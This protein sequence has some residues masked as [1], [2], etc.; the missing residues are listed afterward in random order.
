MLVG[1]APGFPHGIIDDISGLAVSAKK[2]DIPL[3]VDCCLGSFMMPFMR[4]AGYHIPPFDFSVEGVTSISCDTHKYGFAPKGSSIVMYASKEIRKYQYF[5]APNWVGGIYASP[6]IAGS[7]PGALVAGCWAAMMSIG[8]NGYLD[9]TR[10]I[11]G[12]ARKIKHGIQQIPELYVIGD[13]Q[14]TVVAFGAHSP[15]NV[16]SLSDLMSKK[17]WNLNAMQY[18]SCVHIAC[19]LLTVSV[20]DDFVKDLKEAVSLVKA[21][22][23]AY[24][25]GSAAMYGMAASIPDRS[26]VEDI[27]VGFLDLL[28]KA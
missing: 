5:S 10:K 7:R 13:P 16:Y 3:H 11:V 2:H 23:K 15:I 20:A 4:Q 26:I 6:T 9:A 27:T 19:T 24:D 14:V 8:K 12:A 28:T 22:P 25:K 1:S 17:G 21:N 18:P